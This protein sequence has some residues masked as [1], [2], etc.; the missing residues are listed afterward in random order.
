MDDKSYLHASQYP[1]RRRRRGCFGMFVLLSLIIGAIM[2]LTQFTFPGVSRVPVFGQSIGVVRIEGAIYDSTNVIKV[3]RS[4]RENPLIKAIVLRLDTPGGAVG[5]SEEIY[6][7]VL[8]AKDDRKKVIVS[9]GNAAASGGYYIASAADEIYANSGTLT[10]S[11]GV[12]AMDWNVQQILQKVGVRPEIL[13][14]GEHKDTGSPLREMSPEDRRLLQGVVYDTYRQFFR[15]VLKS[16][17]KQI[18][19]ALETR[20][21]QVADILAIDYTKQPGAALEL[22]AFTTGTMAAEVGASERSEVALRSMADGRIFT[23]DQA[24]KLG[25]VDKIGTM[26]D[27]IRRA[28]EITGLGRKPPVVE[29]RPESSIPSFLGMSA[30]AFWRE[31]TR[32]QS[33]IE[34]RTP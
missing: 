28:G 17:H 15:T 9:M 21:E 3:L 27:A 1:S 29:R 4:F 10:G 12:I 7:E 34:F 33:S 26:E 8:R 14:S 24:A 23:G 18:D 30:R 31:F 5:A 16:R 32:P 22:E 19:A 20:P 25:L 13:K 2:L 6:R 11:I